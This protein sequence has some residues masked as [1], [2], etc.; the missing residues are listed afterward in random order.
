M[1]WF[2]TNMA[3]ASVAMLVVLLF[4][5]PVAR[6]FGAGPAYALWLLPALR[7]VAP[8]LPS[9]ADFS[10]TLPPLTLIVSVEDAAP[11]PPDGGPGQWVPLLLAIWAGGAAI[12]M[13]WQIAAYRRFERRLDATSR[14]LGDHRGLGL[15]ESEAVDGPLALG[16]L[17][18]R[19]V[20]PVDFE[21]RYSPVERRL[22]L[23]HE[24]VHHR[25][26]DLW[27]NH[28]GLVILALNWFNPLAWAAWRAFRADQ[29]LACDAAVTAS[30]LPSERQ[31]YARALIKSASRPGLVAACPLN[32]A[33]QLKRRLQM[34]KTHRTSRLRLLGGA[35]AVTALVA[36]GLAAGSPGLAAQQGEAKETTKTENGERRVER[37]I[38][39]T[40]GGGDHAEHRA[41][42]GG[43]GDREVRRVIVHTPD[44]HGGHAEG[45]ADRHRMMMM[46]LGDGDHEID[47]NCGGARRSEVNEGDGNQR[48]RIVVCNRGEATPAQQAEHLQRARER[49][50]NDSELSAEHR[51]RVLAAIDRELA[52][53]RGQ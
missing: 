15:F 33:D 16:L 10:P 11:L 31:D 49:L 38:I 23:D 37:I 3:W 24:T 14:G 1:S 17:R 28:V 48:T 40:D 47:A 6:L 50:A 21:R 53:L 12:F 26:G 42:A 46:H 52:R 9:F 41:H 8:P 36:V 13:A 5:R 27:W 29:E 51:Q 32:H 34:M 7:L 25:R 18:R 4:R 30:A 35:A 20:V 39:R 43:E 2:L 19:I 22:A 45:D 44:G